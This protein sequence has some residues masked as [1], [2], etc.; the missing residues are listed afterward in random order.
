MVSRR[1]FS[2][3]EVIVA[4]TV[5]SIG[6]LAVASSGLLAGRML[7]EAELIEA[8]GNRASGV[9]DSLLMNDIQGSGTVRIAQHRIA[10]TA[11]ARTVTVLVELANE[12]PF[13][14]RASR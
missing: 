5:L 11:D 12:R 3:V 13:V 7:R 4:L 1:G 10:W 2:L 9:L 8:V 6:L 14:M